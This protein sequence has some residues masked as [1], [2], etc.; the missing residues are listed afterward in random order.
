M[1]SMRI[2][3]MT[4]S[5]GNGKQPLGSVSNRSNHVDSG[6]SKP[7]APT[8]SPRDWARLVAKVEVLASGCWQWRGYTDQAGY[9]Q[10]TFEGQR[11]RAH[12][13][14]FLAS[15]GELPAGLELD[16]LCRNRGC[17]NPDHL[18]A[19]THIENLRR[20][21]A[22]VSTM[23]AAQTHCLRGH[24]FDETNTDRRLSP[25]G[26]PRRACKACAKIRARRAA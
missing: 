15:G 10:A 4:Y 1:T 22:Q 14:L 18:E 6:R 17:V 20:A 23:H 21:P 8:E 24:A 19:V 16:H 5:L 9:G 26:R 12:T 25:N 11:T 2:E 13:A 7:E 3:R